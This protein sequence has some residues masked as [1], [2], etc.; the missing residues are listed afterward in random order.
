VSDQVSHPYKTTDTIRALYI[1]IF[2]I[3]GSRLEDKRFCTEW[4]QAFPECSLLF[5]YSRMEFESVRVVHKYSNWSALSKDLLSI[6]MLWFL[7]ASWSRDVIRYLVYS[8]FI[9]DQSP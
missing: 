2:T 1:L 6:S 3:L 7:P 4:Q 9:L 5:I 8:G